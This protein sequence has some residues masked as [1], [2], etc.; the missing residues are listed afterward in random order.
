MKKEQYIVEIEFRYSDKPKDSSETTTVSRTTTL[1][2]FDTFD[3]AIIVGNKALETL[4]N[5]FEIHTY[6]D[7][8]KALQERFSKNGGC[9][10][11]PKTLITNLA[12]LKTPFEFYAKIRKVEEIDI[13]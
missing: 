9:F 1:G 10:G 6:P 2:V 3:K 11:I 5:N 7:G 8:R 4:E 12:Y 13:Q